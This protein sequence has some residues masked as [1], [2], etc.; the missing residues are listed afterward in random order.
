MF[1]R[2]GKIA[3]M[4]ESDKKAEEIARKATENHK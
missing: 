2:A 1:G 3:Q 4:K